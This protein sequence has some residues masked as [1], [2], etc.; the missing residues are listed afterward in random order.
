LI[1]GI[2]KMPTNRA[3]LS[4]GCS[5]LTLLS[6]NVELADRMG[7]QGVVPLLLKLITENVGNAPAL[8][9]IYP[10]LSSLS[11][12]E[13]NAVNMSLLVM[14]NLAQTFN[15]FPQDHRFLAI[16]FSL[17]ANVCVFA[18]ATSY[19]LQSPDLIPIIFRILV[20][21]VGIVDTLV[22]GLKALENVCYGEKDVKDY[23][24]SQQI[25][26]IVTKIS[27]DN[28][29]LDVKRQC[30]AVLDALNRIEINF[31]IGATLKDIQARNIEWKSARSLLGDDKPKIGEVKELPEAIRN[32][33][34]AGA[35]MSKH[36]LTAIPRP[37]HVYVTPDLKFLVWKDPKKPLHP[38]NKMKIS[39]IRS[40]ERGRCTPQLERKSFNKFLAKEECAFA[41]MG[42]DRT[43]DLE[44]ANEAT[45]EKWIE[46][47]ET[48]MAYKKELKKQATQFHI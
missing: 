41:I 48:L 34:L 44:A 40:L 1:S 7:Q 39:R 22:R 23:L 19:C 15:A 14:N 47:L 42:R 24:R 36:S 32:F 43:V 33:L 6:F 2:K 8:M 25:V 31:D 18:Q 20:G 38:D 12:S 17:L 5:A 16:A 37:R 4:N 11:R 10:A 35:L 45:R 30:Q 9:D 27:N 26:E 13:V 28:A 46:A 21:H 29:N 3:I